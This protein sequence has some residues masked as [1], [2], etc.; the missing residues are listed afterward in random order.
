M[1][2]GAAAADDGLP[3]RLKP[4]RVPRPG[5][6]LTPEDIELHG[7]LTAERFALTEADREETYP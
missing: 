6:P 1:A 3:L 5:D 7:R 2:A 4:A